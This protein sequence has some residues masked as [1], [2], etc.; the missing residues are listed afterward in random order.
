MRP[1]FSA[2]YANAAANVDRAIEALVALL[3]ARAGAAEWVVIVTSD[4]G[5][6]LFEDGVLGHGL[7]LDATQTRVPLVV[8]GLAGEWPEPIGL[9]DVRAALQRSLGIPR[10]EA[11]PRLRFQPDAGRSVLQYMAIPE[12]PRLLALRGLDTELRYDTTQPADASDPAF[13]HADLV[14]GGGPVRSRRAGLRRSIAR[15]ASGAAARR[16][17][18]RSRDDPRT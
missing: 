15:R 1:P 5:E 10:G 13:A 9:S 11:P 6:A 3:R 7:M 14:V 2:T 4:H 8:S 12:Q 16:C 17:R 18:S